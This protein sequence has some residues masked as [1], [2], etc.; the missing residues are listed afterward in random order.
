MFCEVVH[1]PV[2]ASEEHRHAVV[3]PGDDER[4]GPCAESGD[5]VV[6]EGIPHEDRIIAG[7]IGRIH[8][9]LQAFH[10]PRRAD[11][12]ESLGEEAGVDLMR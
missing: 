5:A 10:H 4:E 11:I 2:A 7:E 1:V 12:M 8:G 3:A 9:G 6:A